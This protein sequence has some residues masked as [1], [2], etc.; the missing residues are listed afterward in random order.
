M[1]TAHFSVVEEY[2]VG[3]HV[4][5]E[6]AATDETADLEASI[7]ATLIA[8]GLSAQT[9]SLSVAGVTTGMQQTIEWR[10]DVVYLGDA[11]SIDSAFVVSMGQDIA[12]LS[13]PVHLN[14]MWVP[15]EDLTTDSHIPA[16]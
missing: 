13:N 9:V 11:I 2:F 10:V 14:S 15:H 6:P 7:K 12:T 8:H 4:T 3:S 16:A 1:T 5:G